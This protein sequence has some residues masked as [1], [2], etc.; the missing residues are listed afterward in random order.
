MPKASSATIKEVPKKRKV[1]SSDK[2][3]FTNTPKKR[4]RRDAQKE[5]KSGSPNR[6]HSADKS[7]RERKLGKAKQKEIA[8][9]IE[10]GDDYSDLGNADAPNPTPSKSIE[11]VTQTDERDD[12]PPLHESLSRSTKQRTKATKRKHVPEDETPEMRDQ[13]TIF[14]GN[15]PLEVLSKNVCTAF[16]Y[17]EIRF[18]VYNYSSASQEAVATTYPFLRTDRQS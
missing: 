12:A 7:S 2:D 1:V 15:L 9:E 13:R 10:S 5:P 6:T 4:I 17:A 11:K 8:H 18:N 3:L 16:V 14:V